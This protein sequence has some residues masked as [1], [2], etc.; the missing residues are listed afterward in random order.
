MTGAALF[1]SRSGRG[2][3]R[4]FV[5]CEFRPGLTCSAA[6]RAAW[7]FPLR[8]IPAAQNQCRNSVPA[9]ARRGWGGS[10]RSGRRRRRREDRGLGRGRRRRRSDAEAAREA[11]KRGSTVG[12]AGLGSTGGAG[13]GAAPGER[14]HHETRPRRLGLGV[15]LCAGRAKAGRRREARRRQRS[16]RLGRRGRRGSSARPARGGGGKRGAARSGSGAARNA[17]PERR[18]VR[19]GSPERAQAGRAAGSRAWSARGPVPARRQGGERGFDGRCGRRRNCHVLGRGGQNRRGQRNVRLADIRLANSRLANIRLGNIRLANDPACQHPACA[20]RAARPG[21]CRTRP[22]RH[23]GRR[24]SADVRYCRGAPASIA[25]RRRDRRSRQSQDA[26]AATAPRA[27]S[28]GA[29]RRQFRR[30]SESDRRRR[31]SDTRARDPGHQFVVLQKC[32]HGLSPSPARRTL[33]IPIYNARDGGCARKV[34]VWLTPR[35]A[36][37]G[38]FPTFSFHDDDESL[39]LFR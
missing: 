3:R 25:V 38:S 31:E 28:G 2:S 37:L 34:N 11:R 23:W 36:R 7:P 18:P 10:R 14:R 35:A 8:A 5:I 27:V 24:S 12:A 17:E 21:R 33:S 26:I 9:A 13:G 32:R 39:K 30:S 15:L 4:G 6:C 22:A 16:G 19:A 29:D 20:P 1:V